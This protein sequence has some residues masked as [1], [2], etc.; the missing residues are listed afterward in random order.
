MAIVQI[1]GPTADGGQKTVMLV[2]M[3]EPGKDDLDLGRIINHCCG[4]DLEH[5]Y[6]TDAFYEST[7]LKDN[8]AQAVL[9]VLRDDDPMQ[10]VSW[11]VI[12][13]RPND[14]FRI[15]WFHTPDNHK[16]K[17]YGGY[18]LRKTLEYLFNVRHATRVTL[19]DASH[20]SGT[21]LYR[22]SMARHFHVAE[23][24]TEF[25]YRQNPAQV[26]ALVHHQ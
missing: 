24:G 22:A 19:E 12:A 4:I 16:G 11:G 9:L 14:A 2:D 5:G 26:Q 3:T 25:T 23:A 8:G 6:L 18:L 7:H 21:H 15:G 10:T 17:G 20:G 1:V 13:P